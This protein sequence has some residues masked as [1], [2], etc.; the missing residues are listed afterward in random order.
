MS[1]AMDRMLE[2]MNDQAARNDKGRWHI[3]RPIS[4]VEL[5][6]RLQESGMKTKCP[7]V[8]R[9]IE[10]YRRQVEETGRIDFVKEEPGDD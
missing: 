6:R 5:K 2:R 4:E 1:L 10:I 9:R 3:P 7:E 8:E